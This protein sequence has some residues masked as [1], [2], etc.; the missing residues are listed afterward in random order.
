MAKKQLKGSQAKQ[1]IRY[2]SEKFKKPLKSPVEYKT[3]S[4]VADYLA[5]QSVGQ[6]KPRKKDEFHFSVSK[7]LYDRLQKLLNQIYSKS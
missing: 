6:Y 4:D 7:S 1:I 3:A 2:Q 5:R